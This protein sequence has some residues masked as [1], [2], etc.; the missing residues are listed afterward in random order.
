MTAYSF[1]DLGDTPEPEDEWAGPECGCPNGDVWFDRT[2]CPEPCDMMHNRC[3]VCG[4]IDGYCHWQ[5]PDTKS[6]QK[7][8]LV[9]KICA[10]MDESGIGCKYL[11]DGPNGYYMLCEFLADKFLG[12]C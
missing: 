9:D 1:E 8:E 12:E 4:E 3:T 11:T 10:W 5:D 6:A 7:W 2:I